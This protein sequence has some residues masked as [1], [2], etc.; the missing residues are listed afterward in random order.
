MADPYRPK[1][2]AASELELEAA[3]GQTKVEEDLN[4][5]SKQVSQWPAVE[6]R[7]DALDDV[8]SPP[9][10]VDDKGKVKARKGNAHKDN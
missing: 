3:L 8:A 4:R 1:P 2:C 5:R 6:E 10:D 7:Y 9:K